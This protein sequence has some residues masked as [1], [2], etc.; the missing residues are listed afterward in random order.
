[1]ECSA[2][3]IQGLSVHSNS[4]SGEDLFLRLKNFSK[5]SLVRDFQVLNCIIKPIFER[6]SAFIF[7]GPMHCFSIQIVINKCFLLKPEK[8][9]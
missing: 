2:A 7:K 4:D 9:N 6:D 1:M 8:K 5:F 3:N